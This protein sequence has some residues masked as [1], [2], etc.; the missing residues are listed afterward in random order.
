MELL[1]SSPSN[2]IEGSLLTHPIRASSLRIIAILLLLVPSGWPQGSQDIKAAEYRAKATF[3]ANFA[4]VVEWPGEVFPTPQAPLL[5]CVDGE[6]SFGSW[7]AEKTGSVS[8]EGR[9]IEVRW[10]RKE[11]IEDL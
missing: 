10:L 1:V 8:L 4:Y 3:H 11:K 6:F 7:L 5:I 9:H 2:K